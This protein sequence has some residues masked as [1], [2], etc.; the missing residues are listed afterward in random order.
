MYFLR[1]GDLRANGVEVLGVREGVRRLLGVVLLYV[2]LHGNRGVLDAVGA[3]GDTLQDQTLWAT[4]QS[5]THIII[6]QIV[7]FYYIVDKIIL[8]PYT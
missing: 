2:A 4:M 1:A 8:S 5:K 7:I 3:L 6:D